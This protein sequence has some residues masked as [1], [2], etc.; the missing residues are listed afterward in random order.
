MARLF[1][2]RYGGPEELGGHTVG[3]VPGGGGAVQPRP[4]GRRPH[5]ARDPG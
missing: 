1:Q 4:P 3:L 2:H 5:P